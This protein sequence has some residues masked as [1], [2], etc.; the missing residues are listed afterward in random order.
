MM[1]K[2]LEKI[3]THL[4][5]KLELKI[6]LLLIEKVKSNFSDDSPFLQD[7]IEDKIYNFYKQGK[8]KFDNDFNHL[9]STLESQM[10]TTEELQKILKVEDKFEDVVSITFG[11]IAEHHV[12][13]KQIKSKNKNNIKYTLDDFKR[14]KK[15]YEDIGCKVEIICL[16]DSINVRATKAYVMVVRNAVNNIIQN[17]NILIKYHKELTENVIW[18]TQYYDIRRKRK[19]NKLKR[20]NMCVDE[21]GEVA[22]IDNKIGTT[23]PWSKFP[24]LSK[25]KAF[26]EESGGEKFKG[27]KGEGNR[28]SD[29][30]VKKHGIGYHGDKERPEGVVCVRSGKNPSM[31]MHF[32]WYHNSERIGEHVIIKLNAGDIYY[33]C[34]KAGGADWRRR[35]VPTLRHATGAPKIVK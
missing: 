17:S 2:Q 35:K 13:M 1:E 7:K 32:Q 12:G 5:K 16:N 9:I 24:I 21:V 23:H 15:K 34:A 11:K 14:I 18:D 10:I 4:N 30:G 20:A 19:L 22:D 27:L 8:F 3:T 6:K 33:M 31:D 25:I 29:G 28:Y 26:I